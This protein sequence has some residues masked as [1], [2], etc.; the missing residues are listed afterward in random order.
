MKQEKNHN[1]FVFQVG[2]L[3]RLVRQS[4]EAEQDLD[5]TRAQAKMLIAIWRNP[6]ITQQALAARLDIATMS[7]CRQVD[8]LEARG[9]IERRTDSTDR[10]VRRL[11]I[12]E[13]TDPVIR[14]MLERIDRISDLFL[15]ALSKAERDTLLE[16]MDRVI[17]DASQRRADQTA[18]NKQ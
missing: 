1:S 10:R 15:S 12:T 4:F 13:K 8:A 16:L 17:T 14:P 3:Y 9:M 7:V 18:S 5:V 11:F 2:D 6:G